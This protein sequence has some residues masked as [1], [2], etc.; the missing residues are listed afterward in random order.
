MKRNK[1]RGLVLKRTNYKET[2]RIVSILTEDFGRI[3]ALVKGVRKPKSRMA[4]GIEPFAVSKIDFLDGKGELVTLVSARAEKN[5]DNLVKDYDRGALGGEMLRLMNELIEDDVD[6]S[7]FNLGQNLFEALD[8]DK[9]DLSVIETWFR[10]QLSVL[11]GREPDLVRDSSGKKLDEATSYH[12][13]P[14][15]GSFMASPQGEFSA[16]SIKAWR[17]L[18]LKTPREVQRVKGLDRAIA[19]NLPALRLF[20]ANNSF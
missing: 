4:G 11:L 13:D 8:D 14:S 10:L 20:M 15:E 2:D 6:T 16:D 18:M 19:D 1:T 12:F 9:L 5:Y 7:F 17:I 3:S